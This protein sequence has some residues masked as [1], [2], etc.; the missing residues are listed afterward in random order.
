[1]NDSLRAII[2]Y[3]NRFPKM[4]LWPPGS[5]FIQF[6][7]NFPWFDLWPPCDKTIHFW[8]IKY[9]VELKIILWNTSYLFQPDFWVAWLTVR[10]KYMK[11]SLGS[12]I[13]LRLSLVILNIFSFF[14]G[15]TTDLNSIKSIYPA[16]NHSALS[17]LDIRCNNVSIEGYSA[18]D[19]TKLGFSSNNDKAEWFKAG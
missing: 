15:L 17:L 10:S 19:H 1:M 9:I 11:L 4:N 12:H 2:W 8:Y 7:P 5:W 14:L 18:G 13:K 16:L 3:L 6:S